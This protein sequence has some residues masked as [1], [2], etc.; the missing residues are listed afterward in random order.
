M[1]KTRNELTL[2]IG[3]EVIDEHGHVNNVV[4]VGW[5]QAAAMGVIQR[6]EK[7]RN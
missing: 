3:P 6:L 2:T 4:Y 5:M 7:C 1:M